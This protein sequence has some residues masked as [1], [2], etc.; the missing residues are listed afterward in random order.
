M[1]FVCLILALLS[2]LVV[3]N[4]PSTG[5]FSCSVEHQLLE[6]QGRIIWCIEGDNLNVLLQANTTGW[7]G[8]GF[9]ATGNDKMAGADII[10]GYVAPDGTVEINDFK[11]VSATAAP[12]LDSEIEG[13]SYDILSSSGWEQDGW[14]TLRFTRALVSQDTAADISLNPSLPLDVLF[15]Y[16]SED[17]FTNIH[18]GRVRTYL[19]VYSGIKTFEAATEYRSING[20]GNN[21][22][23]PTW[24]SIGDHYIWKN[25]NAYANNVDS[26]NGVSR[27]AVRNISNT[28]FGRPSESLQRV[29][30]ST[31]LVYFGQLLAHDVSMTSGSSVAADVWPIEI[32]KGDPMF[33]VNNEGASTMGFTRSAWDANTGTASD[34]PRMQTNAQTSYMD[35]SHVYGQTD[36]RA[37]AL[38][39]KVDGKMLL[40]EDGLLPDVPGVD[41]ASEAQCPCNMREAGDARAN[42]HSILFTLHTVFV[43]EH[44]RW[45]DVL[46]SYNPTWDDEKLYQ[47]ARRRVVAI[48]QKISM[49][50]YLPAVL[51]KPS[52]LWESY[53]ATTPGRLSHEFNVCAFR[54]GHS[55]LPS[56][57]PRYEAN[58]DEVSGGHLSLAENLFNA[59]NGIYE[60]KLEPGLRGVTRQRPGAADLLMVD[61]ARNFLFGN[62][63]GT[64]NGAFDLAAR[65]M[66]RGRD[67][68]IADYNQ[69]RKDYGLDPITKWEEVTNDTETIQLLN[70]LFPDINDVDLYVGGLAEAE[71]G[72]AIVGPLYAKILEDDFNRLRDTDRFWFENDQ[73]T[74]Q[75]L[76]EI[77]DTRLADV[78]RR[79]TDLTTLDIPNNAFFLDTRYTDFHIVKDFPTAD[80]Y[81]DVRGNIYDNEE[82]IMESAYKM[83]WSADDKEVHF[84]LQVKTEG[85]V[86]IGFD[87]VQR[88]LMIGADMVICRI[89]DGKVEIKDYKAIRNV[90]KPS[91]D[92]EVNGV[93]DI[94]NIEGWTTNGWSVFKFSRLRDTSDTEADNI[95]SATEETLT[96]FAYQAETNDFMYH[97]RNVE[98]K[99][100][101][102]KSGILEVQK[103]LVH[104]D[105]HMNVALAMTVLGSLLALSALIFQHIYRKHTV[106]MYSSPKMNWILLLGA[107]LGYASIPLFS[108]D[109]SFICSDGGIQIV[110]AANSAQDEPL[111]ACAESVSICTSRQWLLSLGFTLMFGSM[112]SKTYRVYKLFIRSGNG[113]AMKRVK[114]TNG[115]LFKII[116]ILVLVDVL[117]LLVW[118][119]VDPFHPQHSFTG[120][121]EQSEDYLIRYVDERCSTD[122][123]I[124]WVISF[125]IKGAIMAK[126]AQ[127]SHA[128]RNIEMTEMS[129]FSSVGNA[130]Y[131]ML[132]ICAMVLPTL[133]VLEG[134]VNAAYVLAV[135]AIFTCCT[136][137]I[138]ILF[139]PQVHSVYNGTSNASRVIPSLHRGSSQKLVQK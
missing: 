13:G 94:K 77:H 63:R 6:G 98:A 78:L 111:A 108:V 5:G 56:T 112:F 43:R 39:S 23:N 26:P 19:G 134:D 59:I 89:V 62:P 40:D 109:S 139:G 93:D 9:S 10:M 113:S 24:G 135:G 128:T 31:L 48:W 122:G 126:S 58:G 107:L 80:G 53:D 70:Q 131:T 106:V 85:W 88:G 38:R 114:I 20:S 61:A 105:F 95:I 101:R 125:V 127:M 3:A 110:G 57:I 4:F 102:F 79:N 32:P 71:T 123:M 8:V 2:Q 45:C 42:V 47:E 104:G 67:H 76:A 15:A 37:M 16:G 81:P 69:V 51:G 50:E 137:T 29:R 21:V 25:K 41:M 87:P 46:K 136:S 86:G 28:L 75:E 72:A 44:N 100:I 11:G 1:R 22:A 118:T 54:Y 34:N 66:Q 30:I 64:E 65:S 138:V 33:D 103:L 133:A 7:V 115:D 12:T 52:V 99:V 49:Y 119:L 90:G 74:P 129:D 91:E 83:R 132:L 124:F 82:V 121:Q 55:E 17:S 96:I 84:M 35:A 18:T 92:V 97:G 130:S 117:V 68:G 27:P 36:E 14:T 60:K 120:V 116:G 73:F